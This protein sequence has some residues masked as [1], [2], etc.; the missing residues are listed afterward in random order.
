[1]NIIVLATGNQGK[2]KEFQKILED[3]PFEIKCLSDFGPLP[4]VEEDGET[5]DDNAYKKAVFT[6]KV[7]G[8]PA[9]ADDSGLEVEA[10]GGKP[11]VH[12][13]RYAGANASDDENI[14]KLLAELDGVEDRR[15]HFS[16]VIS[17]AVPSGPALT[18]VGKCEGEITTKVSGDGGFGYD[19]VFFYP[20]LGKTFA[21]IPLEEKNKVS[22]RGLA[23]AE[24][25]AEAGKIATWLD[26]RITEMKPSKPDHE[27][28]EDNDWSK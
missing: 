23:L 12:S 27:E 24:V 22:H 9:I 1:M 25:A 15:A 28:F 6:A 16:C 4:P 13:A 5:F 8:L 14:Q 19:P 21:E 7:L 11:G 3:F 20:P 2:V 17:I 26:H 18:Y 10:L